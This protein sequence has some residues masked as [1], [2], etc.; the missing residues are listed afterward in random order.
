MSEMAKHQLLGQNHP[1]RSSN[2]C[3]P[4]SLPSGQQ[5]KCR[6]VHVPRGVTSVPSAAICH[7]LRTAPPIIDLL[8]TIIILA[9]S[10]RPCWPSSPIMSSPPFTIPPTPSH[11]KLATPRMTYS[12]APIQKDCL[13][14]PYAADSNSLPNFHEAAYSNSSPDFHDLYSSPGLR[15]LNTIHHKIPSTII[16]YSYLHPPVGRDHAIY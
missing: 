10:L 15:D 3:M 6:R 16:Q 13:A 12:T 14:S 2:W 7:C 9:A 5:A 11:P 1:S 8:T 4:P